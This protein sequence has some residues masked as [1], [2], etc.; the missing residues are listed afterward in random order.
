MALQGSAPPEERIVPTVPAVPKAIAPSVKPP[1]VTAS[2]A[3]VADVAPTDQALVPAS[4][5][6]VV[7]TKPSRT[8]QAMNQV[9]G[10]IAD[11]GKAAMKAI[12]MGAS[13]VGPPISYGADAATGIVVAGAKKGGTMALQGAMAS[14]KLALQGAMAGGQL[15]L[16][17]AEQWQEA[18]PW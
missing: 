5:T 8:R 6:V 3:P 17:G 1:T 15:A 14:G 16:G 12:E 4:T 13:A 18:R 7:P 9:S 11:A 2:I 10:A